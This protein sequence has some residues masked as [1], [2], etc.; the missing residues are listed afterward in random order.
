MCGL[1]KSGRID[2]ITVKIRPPE[3]LSMITETLDLG[4]RHTT[5]KRT[6]IT[7]KAY[8]GMALIVF[9][10]AVSGRALGLSPAMRGRNICVWQKRG[11]RQ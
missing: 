10:F 11:Y 5:Q 1:A 3:A 7:K 6:S 8:F 2:L 9:S 4:R